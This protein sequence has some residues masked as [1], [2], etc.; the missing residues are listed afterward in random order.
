MTLQISTEIVPLTM[1]DNGVIRIGKTRVTLESVIL[2]FRDG[3]TAEE[4][5][6]QYPSLDL[7]D[8]YS[9]ITYYLRNRADVDVYLQQRSRKAKQIQKKNESQFDPVG[10]R[11]RLLA[12]QSNRNP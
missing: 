3:T 10:I 2:S 9:V 6:Q 8:V 7:A 11:A 12:R 5:T 1:D 4:I